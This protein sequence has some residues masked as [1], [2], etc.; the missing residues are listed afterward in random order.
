M[1][2]PPTPRFGEHSRRVGRPNKMVELE[3]DLLEMSSGHDIPDLPAAMAN[4]DLHKT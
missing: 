1:S 4:F 3:D 2:I